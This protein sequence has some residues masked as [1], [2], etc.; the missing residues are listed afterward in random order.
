MVRLFENPE[1]P[2]ANTPG[3]PCPRLRKPADPDPLLK[4]HAIRSNKVA[5]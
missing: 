4:H 5:F 1:N 2:M 3:P